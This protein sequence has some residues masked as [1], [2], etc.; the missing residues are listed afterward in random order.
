MLRR[1]NAKKKLTCAV[2]RH[3]SSS[4][5]SWLATHVGFQLT[6]YHLLAVVIDIIIIA[7][8]VVK[9]RVFRK[10]AEGKDDVSATFKRYSLS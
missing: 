10:K 8:A 5:S 3:N 4:S 1:N 7:R 2:G 9:N 6:S